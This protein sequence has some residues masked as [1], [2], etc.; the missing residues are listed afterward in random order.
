MQTI[1]SVRPEQATGPTRRFLEAF[2]KEHGSP[3]NMLKTMAHAPGVLEAYIDFNRE[4]EEGPLG[5]VLVEKIAL[6]VA[7]AEQSEYSLAFHAARARNL[8]MN[9]EEILSI[10]EGRVP[11]KNTKVAL[12]FARAISR[13]TGEYSV[14]DLRSAG[15]SDA[16]I[17]SI[18]ACVGLNS[19]ANLFNTVAK[20]EIDFPRV[21]SASTAA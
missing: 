7:Q 3:S 5:A 19:F 17:V 4:L 2:T 13:R 21:T 16:E 15:Y 9:D 20:T 8:G 11:D 12:R 10:R 14:T 1:P 6:T 18:V